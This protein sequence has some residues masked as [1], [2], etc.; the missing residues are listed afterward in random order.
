MG[1][2]GDERLEQAKRNAEVLRVVFGLK[3]V[4]ASNMEDSGP[5]KLWDGESEAD[6]L[7]F[8]PKDRPWKTHKIDAKPL[9]DFYGRDAWTVVE[10]LR[11]EWHEHN[12]EETVFWQF[13]DC[14]TAHGWRVDILHGHHD[15]DGL[16]A[17]ASAETLPE[18]I[19]KA[20]LQFRQHP[21]LVQLLQEEAAVN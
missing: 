1:Y 20:A 5:P 7:H 13:V 18:A 14:T 2:Y 11:K 15:G 19:C 12:P 16:L 6:D 10:A 4:W 21:P 17:S 8:I 3:K 9:P